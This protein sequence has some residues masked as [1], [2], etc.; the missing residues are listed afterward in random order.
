[1]RTQ[2]LRTIRVYG[3][4]AKLLKRRTFQAV[5]RSPQE[6][7]RFLS[8]NFPQ[9][10]SY[11][12]TRHFQIRA[13]DLTIA[14]NEISNPIGSEDVIHITPA[15]CGAGGNGITNIIAGTALIVVSIL[16]PV[17]APVLLPLGIG[18]TLTGVAQLIAPVPTSRGDANDPQA[19]DS[20]IFNGVQNT[21]R[22]G[23]P[24]PCVYGEIVTG[25]VVISL[26]VIEDEQEI[27]QEFV[28]GPADPCPFND[29]DLLEDGAFEGY[30]M[31]GDPYKCGCPE[32]LPNLPD[33]IPPPPADEGNYCE[34]VGSVTDFAPEPGDPPGTEY[35]W[36]FKLYLW[37]KYDIAYQCFD[38]MAIGGESEPYGAFGSTQS[39]VDEVG[40]IW[41]QKSVV[42]EYAVVRYWKT[43]IKYVCTGATGATEH[44]LWKIYYYKDGSWNFT[45][46]NDAYYLRLVNGQPDVG[47][48]TDN[49]HQKT[50][51]QSFYSDN[52]PAYSPAGLVVTEKYKV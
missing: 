31:P 25:S 3:T 11:L 41:T 2:P 36:T 15:I 1:M 34:A 47:L 8:S 9:L 29:P 30:T 23:I 6:A 46:N 38:G 45:T 26:R 27:E 12:S 43:R 24:A 44:I 17:T 19:R 22:E 48:F 18:L 16:L 42:G 14:E 49:T 28:A 4:L 39:G 13:G 35:F 33:Y 5:V 40:S 32:P 10:Q 52:S 7:I 50:I 21:S 37:V 51:N 20:Y